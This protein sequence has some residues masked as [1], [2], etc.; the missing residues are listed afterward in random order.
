[1]NKLIY[2][3]EDDSAIKE[4]ESYALINS[5][6][7][8]S[9]YESAKEL[10]TALEDKIPALILLDI[11]LPDEDGISILK[12]LKKSNLY[13]N[14]PVIMVTAKTAE[15]DAVKGL[16]AGADDYINKPFG[17][18]E[19]ISRVKAVLRRT[20]PS[21]SNLIISYKNISIDELQHKVFVDGVEVE[22]TYKE[23]E[24]LKL[25]ILNSK[26]VLTRDRIMEM[27]WGY[28]F[29]QGNRTV[30]VHIQSIRK[31]LGQSADYIKTVRNVGYKLGD[32][33]D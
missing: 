29:E 8:V 33:Y 5:N 7:D 26:I 27:V 9:A 30:D 16:D 28:D 22:L 18:M 4:L 1:M 19:L 3:V 14:I 20:Q 25:L 31:K 23:Y 15:I 21:Q 24:V 6:F 12:N 11:M 2:V 32:W 17:V 10:Y 13:K